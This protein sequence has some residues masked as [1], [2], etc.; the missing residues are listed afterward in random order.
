MNHRA[1]GIVRVSQR[2]D[3]TGHSPEVQRRALNV[4]AQLHE[5]VL[6]PSDVH[7]ENVDNGK[8]RTK[9]GRA[10]LADRP[11]L[12]Y[13]VEEIEAGRAAILAAENFDRLFRN[14]DVLRAVVRR[15]EAAGGEVWRKDGRVSMRRAQQKFMTTVE[16]AQSEYVKDAATERSWDA[17]ELAIE[18]GKIPWHQT[19]PGYVRNG[20]ST[21]SPDPRLKPVIIRAFKMRRDGATIDDVRQYL[22]KHGIVKSYHGVQHL[23]R[24]RVYVGEIHFGEHTP[25]LKAHEP[26]VPRELFDQVQGLNVPRG[27]RPTSNHLLARAGVLRC[28]SCGS[29]MVIGVQT[30]NGRRY[31]FYRCPPTG[32]CERRV[33]IGA[34][35]AEKVVSDAVRE[36]ISDERGRATAAQK[37]HRAAGALRRTQEALDEAT[38]AFVKAGLSD[39]PVAVEELAKLREAR[40]DARVEADR[41]GVAVS[42]EIDGAADWND[43]P[44]DVQ[45][46]LIV[47]TV[48]SATVSPIGRGA[49]RLVVTL[50]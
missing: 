3:D 37:A 26:I 44:L 7:D 30:S 45:R 12:T 16:G 43:L 27:R 28:G 47:A 29:R 20:D 35:I 15:V 18:Q 6:A 46:K 1:I 2:T 36:A 24:D 31:A 39:E 21:L 5:W 19:A 23:L 14:V 25:N 38:R 33:T 42:V 17:V 34:E 10:S 9:S 11:K 48:E 8:I 22:R 41:A 49:E 4:M 13:A 50:K 32:D 40:D